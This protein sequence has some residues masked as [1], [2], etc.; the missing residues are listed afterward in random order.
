MNM[1][2]F[3]TSELSVT[4]LG[5]LEK[6]GLIPQAIICAEDKPVGRKM[7]ITPPPTKIWAE[8][9]G[10]AVFQP[11]TLREEKESGI[12]EKIKALVPDCD[13]FIVASY[14]KIIPQ[15]LLDIPK[16]GTLNVHPSLLPQLRGPSPIQSAILTLEET[17]VSIMLL[18]ALMD[19]GPIIAQEKVNIPNWPPYAD[20]LESLLAHHGGKM[21]S[22]IIPR[23]VNGEI[24]ATE[25]DHDKATMC[26]KIQKTDGEVDLLKTPPY[27]IF[28]KVRAFQGWPGAF[29]F[30]EYNN[31][32]IR[33]LITKANFENNTLV[34][35]HVK[36][37]GKHEMSYADFLRGQ[38]SH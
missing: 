6:A 16:H 23:W 33:V 14:G 37:E 9:R 38:H 20:E 27:E 10:I 5:E 24:K 32:R 22:E 1:L 11:K 17:G 7:L 35:T 3:G 15:A 34:I 28:R 8:S 12:T 21:L 30:T 13:L 18:D 19:H 4:V 26:K 31:S 2:F 36:P 25:Q 29:F